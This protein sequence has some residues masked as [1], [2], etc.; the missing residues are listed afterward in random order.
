MC[1]RCYGRVTEPPKALG[2]IPIPDSITL[3]TEI[4]TSPLHG[5]ALPLALGGGEAMYIAGEA[6]KR[7]GEQRGRLTLSPIYVQCMVVTFFCF[8][9]VILGR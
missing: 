3:S 5:K 8:I 9:L 6:P 2:L 1:D 7:H 4:D